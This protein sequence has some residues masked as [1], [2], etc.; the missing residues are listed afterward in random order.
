MEAQN[1]LLTGTS[2]GLGRL[3]AMTLA[4]KGH[5]VFAGMRNVDGKNK[6]SAEELSEFGKGV[7]G[8][9][10]VVNMDVTSD[11]QVNAAAQTVVDVGGHIDVAVNSAGQGGLGWQ[12][13]FSIEQFHQVID[14]FLYGAQRVYRAVLPFMR[15]RRSGLVINVT[16]IG[17]RLA[18]PLRQGPYTCAK[19]GLEALSE[20]YHQELACFNIESIT[21]Q[22]GLFPGTRLL[23]NAW[24]AHDPAISA[25]YP[26]Y[27]E[28]RYYK[29]FNKF[30]E[31]MLQNSDQ[32]QKVADTVADLIV[33]P[34]GTRPIRSV[35]SS[36]N[37]IGCPEAEQMN[38][39]FGK[40]QEKL[41]TAWEM[42]RHGDFFADE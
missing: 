10:H 23:A 40:V 9:I 24:N 2:S 34:A 37:I 30:R 29:T 14:V 20:R 21:L 22:P 39:L 38:E 4:R 18:Q 28:D 27:E 42:G 15:K 5:N 11:E 41:M 32:G 12:E 26:P 6:G 36:K 7:P 8:T 25:E 1:V 3:T 16:T 35:V 31:R 19:W 13:E 33:M 17:A